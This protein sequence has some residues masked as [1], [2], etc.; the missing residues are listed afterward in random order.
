MF[1]L[2]NLKNCIVED[3]EAKR[4]CGEYCA[5]HYLENKN[6]VKASGI[7]SVE[8]CERES[9][10]K[11]MCMMHYHRESRKEARDKKDRGKK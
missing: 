5:L 3:C 4:I 2:N 7:C 11:K 9:R 8:G 6:E 1:S 10:A